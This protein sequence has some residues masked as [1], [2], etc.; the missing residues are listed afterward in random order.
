MSPC[1]T[2]KTLAYLLPLLTKLERNREI[3]SVSLIVQF[4]V[5]KNFHRNSPILYYVNIISAYILFYKINF[6]ELVE[7]I[8]GYYM[9]ITKGL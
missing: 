4:F 6:L 7:N 3:S 2:G 1:G 5:L 8:E 9:Y